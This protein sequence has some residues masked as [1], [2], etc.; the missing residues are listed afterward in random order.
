MT[1]DPWEGLPD[2]GEEIVWQG[3]PSPRPRLEWGSA[4]EPAVFA[5]FT[6]FAVFW[7]LMAAR[8][9]GP[10]WTFG[11]LFLAAGL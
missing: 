5:V 9:P 2:P 3:R 4:V 11:L 6:G 1:A 8:T 10:F 7:M